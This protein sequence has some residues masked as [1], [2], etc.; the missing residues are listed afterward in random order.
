MPESESSL[1][2]AIFSWLVLIFISASTWHIWSRITGRQTHSEIN[3]KVT[4]ITLAAL[5]GG[6]IGIWLTIFLVFALGITLEAIGIDLEEWLGNDYWIY[7][8]FSTS[9][10]SAG[11]YMLNEWGKNDWGTSRKKLTENQEEDAE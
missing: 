7:I 10:A 4:F 1:V 11:M 5:I 3:E 9:Q 8:F 6:M 2:I